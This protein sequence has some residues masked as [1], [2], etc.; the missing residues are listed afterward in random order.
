MATMIV[1]NAN[2]QSDGDSTLK[3]MEFV[4]SGKSYKFILNPEEYTL[5]EP[6]RA[7]V[8]QTK[9]GAWIDEFGAGIP[10]ISFKG[11]TG[12][13]NGTKNPKSGFQK[14][15]ELR[16]LIQE[17]Y[18]RVAP[19]RV[20]PPEKELKFYNYTDGQYYVV[21]PITFDLFRSVARPTLYAYNVQLIC[22]RLATQPHTDQRIENMAIAEARRLV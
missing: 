2:H 7:N 19:G 9:A 1:S 4:F 15:A 3:R 12:F 5:S 6:N 13:K 17:V 11:T 22:Q 8:T 16:S 10:M 18:A 14:F 20:V 21:T